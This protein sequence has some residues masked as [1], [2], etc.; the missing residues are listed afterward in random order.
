MI[1]GT[2]LTPAETELLAG[3]G[4]DDV[5]LVWALIH[6]GI[7]TNPP[8]TPDWQPSD[9][10]IA[11]AFG[12]FEKLS[13]LGLIS[14]G[15]MEYID[16][17]PPGRHAPVRH[18]SE[19]LEDVRARVQNEVSAAQV[20]TDWEFACWVVAT[21]A[22]LAVAEEASRETRPGRKRSLREMFSRRSRAW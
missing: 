3:T 5:A 2:E 6:L 10:D 9:D 22:G 20:A 15:R 11:A 16:G 21:E 19:A 14:V 12:S 8:P 7:R 1:E 13:A 17:G 18:V 4:Y